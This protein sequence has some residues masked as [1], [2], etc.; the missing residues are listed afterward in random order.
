MWRFCRCRH[1][2]LNRPSPAESAC[3]SH[4]S[5]LVPA[6]PVRWPSFWRSSAFLTTG[7]ACVSGRGSGVSSHVSLGWRTVGPAFGRAVGP[8]PDHGRLPY[9]RYASSFAHRL[10]SGEFD[11]LWQKAGG[12][13]RKNLIRL[14]TSPGETETESVRTE[15]LKA[16][17][18][19]QSDHFGTRAST[20]EAGQ[21]HLHLPFWT[22]QIRNESQIKAKFRT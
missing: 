16:T 12:E 6:S 18:K 1:R 19:S 8:T 9:G 10:R 3:S 21:N 5:L 20:A 15:K 17:R 2:W 14:R 7:S 4:G 13:K 11:W 22:N